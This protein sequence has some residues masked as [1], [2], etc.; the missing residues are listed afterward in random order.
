MGD[1][2]FIIASHT[3]SRLADM[4]LM[5]CS[6]VAVWLKVGVTAALWP[7]VIGGLHNRLYFF[8]KSDHKWDVLTKKTH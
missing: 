7:N 1:P 5:K 4:H 2:P 6:H 8:Q 3:S